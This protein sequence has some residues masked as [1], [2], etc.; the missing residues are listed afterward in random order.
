MRWSSQARCTPAVQP[1]RPWKTSRALD[2]EPPLQA[3][4]VDLPQP[5]RRLLELIDADASRLDVAGAHDLLTQ[6]GLSAEFDDLVRHADHFG[7]SSDM[8]A[9]FVLVGLMRGQLNKFLTSEAQGALASLQGRTKEAS[10]VLRELGR[11]SLAL[12]GLAQQAAARE[13]FRQQSDYDTLER[14]GRLPE[15]LE[16]LEDAFAQI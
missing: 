7:L 9:A 3:L 5:Y 14:I 1:I 2:I 12:R 8:V 11:Q 6:S 13:L 10:E 4:P 15:F 16:H